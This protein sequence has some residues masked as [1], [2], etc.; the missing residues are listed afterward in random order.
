MKHS[1]IAVPPSAQ[2]AVPDLSLCPC[3]RQPRPTSRLLETAIDVA[4]ERYDVSLRDLRGPFRS[5]H[6]VTAR[7]LIV[8]ALRCLGRGQTYASIGRILGF[9]DHS[10]IINL[11]HK[12]V[13]LRQSSPA[14][15]NACIAI[16]I[17]L[18]GEIREN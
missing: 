2:T 14:F 1:A 4:L 16:A 6:L 15:E 10:T 18:R 11:H 8:W 12:A 17:R 7:A 13:A 3:C 9:R 5:Q